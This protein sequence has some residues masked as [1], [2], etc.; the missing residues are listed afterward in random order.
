MVLFTLPK[1]WSSRNFKVKSHLSRHH[2]EVLIYVLDYDRTP[3]GI[4]EGADV[5]C[6]DNGKLI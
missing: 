3:Q 1:I 2:S 6:F 5:V 4:V